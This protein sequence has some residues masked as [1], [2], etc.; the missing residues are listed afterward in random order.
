MGVL[1]EVWCAEW[2]GKAVEVRAE[3]GA[4][5]GFVYSLVVEGEQV[6]ETTNRLKRPG[7][8]EVTAKVGEH[9]LAATVRQGIVRTRAELTVDGETVPLVAAKK[10]RAKKTLAVA[11]VVVV[12]VVVAL[13]VPSAFPTPPE[14]VAAD[15]APFADT[16]G[17]QPATCDTLVTREGC[18][19]VT[20]TGQRSVDL[21]IASSH[22]DRGLPTLHGT[23]K[24]PEGPPGPHP[25][26]LLIGGSGGHPRDPEMRGGL[27]VH[28]EPFKLYG[29]IGDALVE[30]G[31]AVLAIDKRTCRSCY[32][33]YKP[34]F[35]AFRFSFFAD[36]AADALAAMRSHPE[37]DGRALVVLGHSQGGAF[38][39][40]LAAKEEG[41]A[42]A[43]MLGATTQAFHEVIPGQLRH[44]ADLRAD[45]FDLLTATYLRY[46][47]SAFE[48]CYE[49]AVDKPDTPQ[50]CMFGVTY[51]AF[52]DEAEKARLT[53]RWLR[54]LP[55]PI[56]ALQ[57]QLDRQF[58]PDEIGRIRTALHDRDAE[59]HVVADVG[60]TYV[61]L[62]DLA[63]PRL[64][65]E[66]EARVTA[67][68]ASVPYPED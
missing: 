19:P 61:H 68:L 39:V 43:V 22:P 47:A 38:A 25:G 63:A 59:V 26:V 49:A 42:A 64:A 57:G 66:V 5:K 35:P 56:M 31:F 32:P 58:P 21:D 18:E 17:R 10:S 14:V 67:F 30:Q 13:A 7:R 37:V 20:V 65:P 8:F 52:Q 23:L 27:V 15:L 33:D 54:E 55:V 9:R 50:P 44:F 16:Q 29:A 6:G 2:D 3:M 41:I 4:L 28:H 60:H 40:Q 48:S 11:T 1:G 46:K 34:D 12:V 36:D 62:D 24:L 51:R 45:R 53:G